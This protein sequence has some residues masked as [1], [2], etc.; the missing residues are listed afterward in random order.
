MASAGRSTTDAMSGA[1]R[2]VSQHRSA[3]TGLKNVVLGVAG[4]YAAIKTV[5]FFQESV[6]EASN[7][8]E[9]LNL[10]RV[11]FD[12]NARSVIRWSK[13]S[14]DS[15]G[16]SQN[17]AL[18]ARGQF[19]D[20][21]DQIGFG[22]KVVLGMSDRVVQLATDL[23]SLKNLETD[24]ALERIQ[25]AFRGEYDSL[26]LLIPTISA[27]TVQQKALSMT[28]EE[29]AESLTAQQKAAAT[30]AIITE[31]SSRAQGDFAR[32]S[33]DYAGS[34]KRL[35]ANIDD[36]QAKFGRKLLPAATD[37]IN[38]LNDKGIPVVSGLADY[39]DHIDTDALAKT[40]SGI[41]WGE[42]AAGAGA[43]FT[44]VRDVSGELPSLNDFLDVTGTVLRF[45]ADHTDDLAKA[46][47][48]LAAGY[49]ALKTVQIASNT[50]AALTPALRIAE[51]VTNRRMIASNL[52]LAASIR[53]QTTASGMAVPALGAAVSKMGA[54][55]VAARG[56]AGIGGIGLLASSMS[57]MSPVAD[58]FSKVAGGAALGFSVGGPF[59]AAIGAGAGALWGLGEA[60]LGVGDDA[61]EAAPDTDV[62]TASL[63]QLTGAATK[64]TRSL[65]AQK[66]QEEG[67]LDLAAGIG[68]SGGSLVDAI[69]GKP[70]DLEAVQSQIGSLIASAASDIADAQQMLYDPVNYT[71]DLATRDEARALLESSQ[72]QIDKLKELGGALNANRDQLQADAAE[73]RQ[74]AAAIRG[75]KVDTKDYNAALRDLPRD[76][77][78]QVR[79]MGLEVSRRDILDL[80]KQYETARKPVETLLKV[81]G[82]DKAKGDVKGFVTS[83]D[84]MLGQI[85]DETV[86]LNISAQTKAIAGKLFGD[87]Y[88][89][90]GVVPGYSPGVDDHLARVSGGEAVLRPEVTRAVGPDWVHAVNAAAR[91][92]GVDGARRA[93]AQNGPID[94][95]AFAAGGVVGI[96][97]H[98]S[99]RGVE[100]AIADVESYAG[101][102]AAGIGMRLS[103]AINAKLEKLGG[104]TLPLPAGSYSIGGG[105]GSYPGHTGQDLPA[106][107]GTPI[108][109]ASGGRVSQ[110]LDLTT[111]YGRH[112]YVDHPG[113][114]QTRYAHMQRRAVGTN[115][116][117]LPGGV[118][119]YVDSTGN[120]S[121][122]HLH[123]ETREG[124]AV[125]DPRSFMTA[126]GVSFDSGGILRNGQAGVN[127]S[128]RPEAVLD[129]DET[130]AFK[131]L[132]AA[133]RSFHIGARSSR[134][135][136]ASAVSELLQGLREAF[137]RDAPI[138]TRVTALGD[139]VVAEARDRDKLRGALAEVRDS[140][141]QLVQAQRE[142]ASS[143][144]GAYLHDPLTG[145]LANF[146]VQVEAD[147]NDA[148]SAERMLRRTRRNGLDGPLFRDLAA[149]GNL[150]LI[151]EFSQLGRRGINAR[152]EMFASRASEARQLGG[153]AG[154]TV[155]AERIRDNTRELRHMNR[156]LERFTNRMERIEGRIE[157]AAER[158][159][160]SGSESGSER[161]TRRGNADRDRVLTRSAKSGVRAGRF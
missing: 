53:A 93:L 156:Q 146:D 86:G 131:A 21:F 98:M 35:S 149:A 32:T 78:T 108:F 100:G 26:Q 72:A 113:G 60:L 122:N 75:T 69:V 157:A 64:A 96:T 55:R 16:L 119:G 17:A 132:A 150:Q 46:L 56:A 154:N 91:A 135:E 147:R 126:R 134:D 104:W 34:Q 125:R 155:Y 33:D 31:K 159:T 2:A 123:Y 5:D 18:Q 73:Q 84:Y 160:R 3:L 140:N 102:M 38:L 99:T 139:Q 109:A 36:L 22:E 10:T 144:A 6:R 11:V 103:E 51:I 76:V 66:L 137:G 85:R 12:E 151:R 39:I 1:D 95:P 61:K 50:A 27:A 111:S 88:W 105:V 71:G 129:P 114:V 130:E 161:G 4:S 7:L 48:F 127:Q 74:L 80:Q 87:A 158:G 47:P 136:V 57:D 90:G 15:F 116:T 63:D 8:N 45:A 133:A 40:F 106:G 41:D 138:V 83:T 19:G 77:A 94:W 30:L 59:G 124:G 52:E 89:T 152:E 37:V 118:I 97:P 65:V 13:T 49:L 62:F 29:N 14:A 82:L 28:G 128:G 9:T 42:T 68:I 92:G 25:A 148:R 24:D 121:G 115:A 67:L 141:Q 44:A 20:M 107:L 23:G 143:V 81:L 112:V 110:A 79:Q 43:L 120:S 58:T 142:Y 145:S 54:L 153:F 117:V 101:V 70:G